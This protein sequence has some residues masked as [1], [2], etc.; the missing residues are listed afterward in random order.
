MSQTL[1][2]AQS[3]VLS[4]QSNLGEGTLAAPRTD[5]SAIVTVQLIAVT[6]VP[7]PSSLAVLGVA[8]M[9]VV[10]TRENPPVFIGSIEEAQFRPQACSGLACGM[11]S[12]GHRNRDKKFSTGAQVGSLWQ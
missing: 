3:E 6:D 7:E 1:Q 2:R 5:R 12:P 10:N 9:D 8:A 4:I 11:A